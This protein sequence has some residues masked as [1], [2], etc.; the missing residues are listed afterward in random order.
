MLSNP[1]LR[2]GL[3]I[4]GFLGAPATLGCSRVA[5]C[6]PTPVQP[7]P[8]LTTRRRG[9]WIVVRGRTSKGRSER[10]TSV[11]AVEA[12]GGALRCPVVP[13][14]GELDTLCPRGTQ[15]EGTRP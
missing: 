6:S 10:L 13:G 5:D 2:V 7:C 8:G 4:A 1:G 15:P 11:G 12:A 9:E 14:G 3:R